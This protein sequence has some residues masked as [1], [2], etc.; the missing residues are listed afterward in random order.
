VTAATAPTARLERA[1]EGRVSVIL[2]GDW[3]RIP[4][5]SQEDANEEIGRVIRRRFPRRDEL[6]T[7]RRETREMLRAIARDA[8]EADAVFLA[9]SLELLPGLPFA[10]AL[11]ASYIDIPHPELEMP[12]EVRLASALPNGEVLELDNGLAAREMQRSVPGPELPDA[13]TTIRF[14]YVLPTP[15]ADR[16]V[17]WYANVPTEADPELVGAL[18]D[19]IL[20]TVR[21]YPDEA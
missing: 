1:D 6:A 12:L 15:F 13:F 3:A 10:A 20:G 7:M 9:A 4:L 11:I 21:W 5:E 2:P 8:R 16:W 19:A 17:T 14:H 18:F